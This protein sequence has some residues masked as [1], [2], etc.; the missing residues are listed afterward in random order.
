M[1]FE[2]GSIHPNSFVQPICLWYSE[3]G[4]SETVG[5]V[6]GW[7]KSED[8]S[9]PHEN[10]PKIIGVRIQSN[11][12]C[13]PGEK[14][15]ASLASQKTFCAGLTNGSGVCLGDSGGGLTIKNNNIHYLKG[16]VSSSL[17][18][19]SDCNVM[20]NTI[21]TNVLM[22]RDWIEKTAGCEMT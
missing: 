2:E 3:N 10:E 1:E 20:K 7:G 22:F 4:P 19:G 15:L 11:L 17:L 8:Q 9:K 5:T 13:L 6:I 16:I 18:N 14:E 21:Y 12:D